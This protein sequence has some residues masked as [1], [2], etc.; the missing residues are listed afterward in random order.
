VGNRNKK[1]AVGATVLFFIVAVWMIEFKP[2]VQAPP[3][4][5][6]R[7][8]LQ[9]RSLAPQGSASG[10]GI[11]DPSAPGQVQNLESYGVAV[12]HDISPALRDIP[13]PPDSSSTA[14][15]EM[16]APVENEKIRQEAAARPQ[17]TDPVLQNSFGR[18]PSQ[19][20]ALVTG[21][22]FEGI[23]NLD[24]VYPPDTNGDVGPNHYVQMVNLHLVLPVKRAMMAIQSSCMIRLPTAGS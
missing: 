20:N 11:Q 10:A 22:N 23:S 17:V 18:S 19:A 7:A 1:F 24:S 3:G 9:P 14:V 12:K 21:V 4:I 16:V 13:I 8:A 15:K 6:D 5:A 2:R